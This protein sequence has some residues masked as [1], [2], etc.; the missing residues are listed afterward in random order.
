MS[1][2]GAKLEKTSYK[3]KRIEGKS[4]DKTSLQYQYI[5]KGKFT[6]YK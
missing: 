2:Q 6:C 1:Q 3:K 5:S 4:H